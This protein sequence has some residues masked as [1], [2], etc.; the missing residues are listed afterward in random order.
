MNRCAA[1]SVMSV[2]GLAVGAGADPVP[3]V[4]PQFVPGKE[5]S[6]YRDHSMSA[7]F[8]LTP[9]QTLGWNGLGAATNAFNYQPGF[10]GLAIEVDAMAAYADR[11][12]TPVTNDQVTMLASVSGSNKIAYTAPTHHGGSHGALPNVGVWAQPVAQINALRPPD[13]VDGLEVW[14]NGTPNSPFNANMFSIERDI[15]ASVYAW[16]N[17]ASTATPYI[18][19]SQIANAIG[20]PNLTPMIDVDALMVSDLTGQGKWEA[21][22]R[23]MF[24]LAP[25]V[26][27]AGITVYDGGEIWVWQFGGAA[28]FLNHGGETW[29][30]IH[31]VSKHFAHLGMQGENI[32]ALEAVPAPGSLALLAMSGLIAARR[33]RSPSLS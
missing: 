24:S 11:F 25:I 27:A 23:I 13:D 19:Q 17:T 5:Y 4:A 9:G 21:G 16:N 26:D 31:D 2:V 7:G 22:D 15:G 29:D 8:P 18:S 32:N 6:N 3:P 1:I 12:F 28:T 30:T 20:N 33:R 10:A 14:G